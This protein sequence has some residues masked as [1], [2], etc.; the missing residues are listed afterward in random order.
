MT[1]ATNRGKFI[2]GFLQLQ[3]QRLSLQVGMYAVS[4]HGQEQKATRPTPLITAQQE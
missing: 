3:N 4:R 2:L 1:K